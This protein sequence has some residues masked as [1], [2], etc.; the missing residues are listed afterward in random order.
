MSLFS[1]DSVYRENLHY[2]YAVII[3]DSHFSQ[4][5]Q[6]FHLQFCP[7]SWYAKT[8]LELW[9]EIF[10]PLGCASSSEAF[11]RILDEKM[12]LVLVLVGLSFFAA[13]GEMVILGKIPDC[14]GLNL[15]ND[16]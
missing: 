2:M 9:Y 11:Y 4:F 14:K 1:D 5:L 3:P 12:K 13:F 8:V 15:K 10:F 6:D 16:I 7:V